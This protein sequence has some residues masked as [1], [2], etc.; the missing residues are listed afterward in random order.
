M[1][2][3]IIPILFLAALILTGCQTQTGPS[4]DGKVRLV[5]S[6]YPLYDFAVQAAGDKAVV[7]NILPPG[8]NAHGFEPTPRDILVLESADVFVYNGAGFETW[9][10]KTVAGLQNKGVIVDT[11]KRLKL[12]F[13]RNVTEDVV[14]PHL[15]LSP[16]NAMVQVEL[17]RD[18]LA[19]ADPENAAG[20]GANADAYLARLQDLDAAMAATADTC[21]KREMFVSHAA[22]GYFARDYGIRQ[23]PI[24]NNFEPVGEVS[25]QE[26]DQLIKAA[27]EFNA[28]HVFFEEYVSPKLSEAIAREI[29]G[30]TAVFSPMEAYAATDPE[31]GIGYI[32][33]MEHN[34]LVLKEALE[35]GGP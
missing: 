34:R 9:A 5:A 3:T 10:P 11:S 1:Q 29:G 24:I 12:E 15:W 19:Q 27:R 8:L 25:L 26:I 30:K 13:T 35:C 18:A 4:Q 31:K 32:E 28:T 33:H 22:F 23:V 14:D 20:Y 17:I 16:K 2:K 6:F 7:I 21:Q